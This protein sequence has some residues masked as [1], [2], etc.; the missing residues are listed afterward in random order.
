M[1]SPP[2][3]TIAGILTELGVE[4]V[5]FVEELTEVSLSFNW[6]AAILDEIH[7]FAGSV[8]VLHRII[9]SMNDKVY[10]MHKKALWRSF[11][12]KF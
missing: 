12:F 7:P 5:E 4:E 10:K 2:P 3:F 11:N 6:F 9:I 8:E 1:T